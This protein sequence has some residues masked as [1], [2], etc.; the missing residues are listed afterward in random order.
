MLL[1]KD[2]HFATTG[3]RI[4]ATFSR[5]NQVQPP[6]KRTITVQS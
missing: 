4:G 2:F 5:T 6:E 1:R 3:W